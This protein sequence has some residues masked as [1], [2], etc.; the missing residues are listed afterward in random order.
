MQ[1]RIG[2]TIGDV[3]ERDGD[4]LGDGVNIAARLQSL[5][6]SAGSACRAGCRAVANKLGVKFTDLGD[7]TVKNIPTPV[8]AF[9]VA[10]R[11]EDGTYSK[12]QVKKVAKPQGAPNWMW[13]VAVT[14]VCLAAIGVGGFLYF[15][16][17]EMAP[18]SKPQ[19]AASGPS[20]FRRR[21]RRHRRLPRRSRRRPR[22]P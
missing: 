4:L 18:G 11:R 22:P 8:H 14:V 9:M 6:G 7:Q 15:T 2:I 19:V 17:L 3:V 21:P 20:I 13:P 5:A 12:P 10:M 16:K 1:F